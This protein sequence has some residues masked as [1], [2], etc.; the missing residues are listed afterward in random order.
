MKIK[1]TENGILAGTGTLDEEGYI[2]DCS[3]VL[4]DDQEMS[5]DVYATIE[6]TI[7]NGGSKVTTENYAWEWEIYQAYGP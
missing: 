4:G 6:E 5:E 7:A 2:Q 1:I 3:A